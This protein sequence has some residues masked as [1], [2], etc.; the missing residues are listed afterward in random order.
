MNRVDWFTFLRDVNSRF[1][2]HCVIRLENVQFS[3][4][5]IFG[6]IFYQY[7]IWFG[8]KSSNNTKFVFYFK[9]LNC[10]SCTDLEFT[11]VGH[12]SW[13]KSLFGGFIEHVSRGRT[14]SRSSLWTQRWVWKRRSERILTNFRRNNWR[15]HKTLHSQINIIYWHRRRDQTVNNAL[16]TLPTSM[17]SQT[18]TPT[19]GT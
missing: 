3:F 18:P 9:E 13:P 15:F 14:T 6:M 17:E 12:F 5:R 19:I 11:V 7:R 2:S 1:S 10:F 4:E 16:W 8:L